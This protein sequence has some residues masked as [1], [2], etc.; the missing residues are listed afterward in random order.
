MQRKIKTIIALII[1]IA[2][3]ISAMFYLFVFMND[4]S[5]FIGT[6]EFIDAEPPS[7]MYPENYSLFETYYENNSL[8]IEITNSST[9]EILDT[10]WW[11]YKIE[12]GKL[13]IGHNEND[14][15]EPISYT[16]SNDD[17]RLTRGDEDGH[18]VYSKIS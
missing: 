10:S 11:I 1:I 8:K 9:E 4:K 18:Y 12:F 7:F 15:S 17:E 6:W 2:I 14:F 3:I 5:R 16:F 13:F